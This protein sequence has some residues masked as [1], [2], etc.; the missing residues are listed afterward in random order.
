MTEI[1]EAEWDAKT[2]TFFKPYGLGG[3]EGIHDPLRAAADWIEGR[4]IRVDEVVSGQYLDEA[5]YVMVVYREGR[6]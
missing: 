1:T 2:K 4:D 6:R 3:L 5:I